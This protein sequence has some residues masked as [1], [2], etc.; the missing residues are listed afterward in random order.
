MFDRLM[1]EE[2]ARA[3]ELTVENGRV[4]SQFSQLEQTQLELKDRLKSAERDRRQAL[5]ELKRYQTAWA[6]VLERDR[7]AK[8]IIEES[9]R[10]IDQARE[11]EK[12]RLSL[13]QSLE[14]EKSAR[15]QV[16]RHSKGYQAELQSALV[17]L[18]SSEAKFSELTQELQALREGRKTVDDEIARIEKT[19]RERFELDLAREREKMRGELEKELRPRIET[20]SERHWLRE[21]ATLEA[22]LESRVQELKLYQARPSREEYERLVVELQGFRSALDAE[23]SRAERLEEAL[24]SGNLSFEQ[25]ILAEDPSI[26][27]THGEC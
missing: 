27:Q 12:G 2:K 11:L 15:E 16:E 26:Q 5:E 25:P 8:V 3:G 21:R 6:S 23:T 14:A 7:E 17:R 22:S 4:R 1:H 10:A 19:M 13:T 20:E 18:H 24:V 9:R